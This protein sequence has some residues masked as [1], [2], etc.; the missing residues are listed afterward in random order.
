VSPYSTFTP[1]T[2]LSVDTLNNGGTATLTLIIPPGTP[3]GST[4]DVLVLS[5]LSSN[6]TA[7]WPVAVNTK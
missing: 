6:E 1:A 5:Q 7:Y 2:E 4:A 3:S